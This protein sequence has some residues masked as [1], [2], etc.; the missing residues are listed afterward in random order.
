M[1][2]KGRTPDFP[3]VPPYGRTPP[4]AELAARSTTIALVPGAALGQHVAPSRRERQKLRG[5]R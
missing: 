3:C 1:F 5:S 2:L 4:E